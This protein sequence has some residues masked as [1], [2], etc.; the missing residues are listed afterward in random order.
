MAMLVSSCA[1]ANIDTCVMTLLAI[2][3]N[4]SQHWRKVKVPGSKSI[5]ARALIC[6]YLSGIDTRLVNLPD[7]DDTRELGAALD[8]L[9]RAC[10]DAAVRI[11]EFGELPPMEI[12][13]NLG[14]G[15]T[16]L[17]FFL[18]LAASLPGLVADIDCGEAMRKRPL[19]PLID[20]LRAHGAEIHCHGIDGYAPLTVFGRRLRGGDI[21][22]D[23]GQ[24]SQ[25]VSALLL[26]SELW[27]SPVEN[28]DA[29]T[30][31]QPYVDMTCSVMK[32]FSEH[33]SEYFIEADWTAASYFY[34]LAV[35]CPGRELVMESLPSPDNSVQGDSMC[36]EFFGWIGVATTRLDDNPQGSVMIKGDQSVI[37]GMMRTGAPVMFDM[38]KTPD[39]VPAFSTA[40]CM[41]RL[42]FDLTGIE[43]LRYK[44]SDRLISLVSELSKCGYA[45]EAGRDSLV[46]GGRIYPVADD[47]TIDPWGDHRIAMALAMT[48][49]KRRYVAIRDAQVVAK[50]FPDFY[51]QLCNVGFEVKRQGYSSIVI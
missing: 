12:A 21:K 25:F 23:S 28:I 27:S 9:R 4:P 3:Y 6:R 20:E 13:F 41:V 5:A 2:G 51:T 34:E 17:R 24:S 8:K 26:A 43:H 11:R 29:P 1:P 10:P 48:A 18:A 38:S 22:V 37:S 45:V 39:L 36:G 31:S 50:S 42:P 30:V 32:R 15:G 19:K 47:V 7:C 14:N 40:C 16:S 49:A 46:S 44:E 33:P 35:A